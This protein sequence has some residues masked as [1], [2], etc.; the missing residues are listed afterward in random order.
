MDMNRAGG[1]AEPPPLSLASSGKR[2][3]FVDDEPKV[4]EGLQRMLYPLRREWRMEFVGSGNE[5]LKRLGESEFDVLVTDVRMPEMS[6]IELLAEVVERHPQIIRMVLSGT[7]DQDLTL[8]SAA[9]AHQYLVKPCD[10]K[11][12]REKVERAFSLRVM[13]DDPGLKQV[14]SRLHSI[15]S[16]PAI[17]ARLVQALNAPEIS[18][19]DIGDIVEQDVGLTA[20]V[21]QLANSAF[22]GISR[23]ITR[24]SDA[25][26]YLGVDTV[27]ALSLT[28]SVFSGFDSRKL[29]GFAFEQLQDHS[30]KVAIVAREIAKSL[31][32][33]RSAIDDA[34]VGGLLH[35]AGKFVL[36]HNCPEPYSQ[37]LAAAQREAKP[38][39]ET[40]LAVFGTTHAEVGGY[41]LW[42]WGLSD[43]ITEAVAL[44]HR[45][46]TDS[47]H[48]PGPVVAVHIA[49]ALVNRRIAED[50]DQDYLTRTGLIGYLPQWQ[51][52]GG[53]QDR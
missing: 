8:R 31:G 48:Q 21:L 50:L 27:R 40:E 34:F 14:I 26:V 35:D 28:A 53:F 11:A 29:P 38:V 20:K 25:V 3:L 10:A 39:R 51:Q 36:A 45:L 49:D 17:Y 19:R 6:G 7:V 41:L 24:P 33:V 32:W 1:L 22:L 43:G 18:A 42:L 2:I 46:P 30:L 9:L 5:A 44:H 4:L 13:L 15:P 12:L 47:R 23:R 37:A 52:S 16:I